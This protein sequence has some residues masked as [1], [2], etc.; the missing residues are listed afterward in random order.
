MKRCFLLIIFFFSVFFSVAQKTQKQYM[1]DAEKIAV[2]WLERLNKKQYKDCW[3]MLAEKTQS[4][5]S[6]H[7]WNAY[8]SKELMPELGDFISRKY[9]LAEIEK[10]IE[11]LPEGLYVTIRYQS[12][13]ANA[14]SVDEIILLHHVEN[15]QWKILSYFTEY[16]LIDDDGQEPKSKL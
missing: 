3:N 4:Q 8:F 14:E 16:Q 13:Y 6:F 15:T 12:E 11:G 7:D 2:S 10:Q 5:T 9:Y 1:R